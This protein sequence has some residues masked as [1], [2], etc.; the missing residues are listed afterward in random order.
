MIKIVNN[1]VYNFYQ[2]LMSSLFASDFDLIRFV[3]YVVA[4]YANIIK[5]FREKKLLFN[6]R[7][8]RTSHLYPWI[9]RETVRI[10]CLVQEKTQL[11]QPGLEAGQLNPKSSATIKP[12]PHPL[13][14]KVLKFKFEKKNPKLHVPFLKNVRKHHLKE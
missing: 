11:L 10:K 14:P 13:F 1:G 9:E 12:L 5:L 2:F 3:H 6:K 7:L 4:I 8:L